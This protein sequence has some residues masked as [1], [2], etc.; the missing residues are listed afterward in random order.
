M[1]VCYAT[2]VNAIDQLHN[3]TALQGR[4]YVAGGMVPWLFADR[5]SCRMHGDIDLVV[6]QHDMMRFRHE[7]R[8]CGYYNPDTDARVLWPHTGADHGFDVVING[9]TVNI[10]PFEIMP[11]GIIQRNATYIPTET[12]HVAMTIY[13]PTLS[14][15]EYVTHTPWRNDALLGH[16]PYALV[17]ATKL[18]TQR[19]K[20]QHDCRE[21]DRLGVCKIQVERYQHVLQQMQINVDTAKV[22]Q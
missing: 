8:R 22:V 14:L 3:A 21:L 12:H 19:A 1:D 5:D 4:F 11:D 13:L 7:M 16:Y 2:A 10:A 18:I 20:D 9:V 17:Y 15:T 6:A